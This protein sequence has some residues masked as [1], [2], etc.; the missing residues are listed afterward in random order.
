MA[1]MQIATEKLHLL[2]FFFFSS[3]VAIFVSPLYPNIFFS[4]KWY[5]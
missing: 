5:C 1:Q 3:E 4:L 2:F